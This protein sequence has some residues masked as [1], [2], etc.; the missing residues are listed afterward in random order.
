MSAKKKA[1]A[2][3]ADGLFVLVAGVKIPLPPSFPMA[4]HRY[5]TLVEDAVVDDL[6]R[7]CH[8]LIDT[9][10]HVWHF[11]RE[12]PSIESLLTILTHEGVEGANEHH[13]LDLPH[14]VICSVGE[15]LGPIILAFVMA[16]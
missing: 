6:G 1:P 3:K 11:Q 8:S 4:G 12:W 16:Q 10:T 9:L 2:K 13:E 7:V 14:K 5:K 15:T